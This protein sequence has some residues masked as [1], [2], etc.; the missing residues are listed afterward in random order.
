[1]VNPLLG[2]DS[3]LGSCE[4]DSGPLQERC[5]AKLIICSMTIIMRPMIRLSTFMDFHSAEADMSAGAAGSSCGGTVY[6]LSLAAGNGRH[7]QK[8]VG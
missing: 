3:P 6:S 4:D 7:G 2:S 8:P 5:V 1:M